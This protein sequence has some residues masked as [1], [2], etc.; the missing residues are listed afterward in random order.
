[1]ITCPGLRRKP[2][3]TVLALLPDRP[4][5]MRGAPRGQHGCSAVTTQLCIYKRVEWRSQEVACN[6]LSGHSRTQMWKDARDV[7]P[8]P[9]TIISG[10]A[11]LSNSHCLIE[12]QRQITTHNTYEMEH[13]QER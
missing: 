3:C 1:M 4:A 12:L 5:W 10:P 9:I 11:A 7:G 6:Y 2:T 13:R 8:L